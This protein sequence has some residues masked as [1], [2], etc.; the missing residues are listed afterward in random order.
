MNLHPLA[1]K[2]LMLSKNTL[3]P[4]AISLLFLS[5]NALIA[6]SVKACVYT[7]TQAA[8]PFHHFYN[9][10]SY[11]KE[12]TKRFGTH[13]EIDKKAVEQMIHCWETAAKNYHAEAAYRLANLYELGMIPSSFKSTKIYAQDLEKALTYY[14]K[15]AEFGHFQR[16]QSLKCK[17]SIHHAALCRIARIQEALKKMHSQT[18]RSRVQHN[19]Q[20]LSITTQSQPARSFTPSTPLDS[21]PLKKEASEPFIVCSQNTPLSKIEEKNGITKQQQA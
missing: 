21:E 14:Q 19:F 15:A 17:I 20:R 5:Q 8:T 18:L 12:A 7:S 2:T 1:G 4:I 11:L 10:I 9:G 6:S 16:F 3:L 13:Q